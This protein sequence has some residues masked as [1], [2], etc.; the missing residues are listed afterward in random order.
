MNAHFLVVKGLPSFKVQYFLRSYEYFNQ[1]L[2]A[3]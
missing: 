3:A 1:Y 2:P